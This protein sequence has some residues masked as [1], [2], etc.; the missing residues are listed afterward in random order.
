MKF[1]GQTEKNMAA[2]DVKIQFP[3]PLIMWQFA[4]QFRANFQIHGTFFNDIEEKLT[5][6]NA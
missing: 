3:R 5:I 6:L 1:E 2:K 4:D